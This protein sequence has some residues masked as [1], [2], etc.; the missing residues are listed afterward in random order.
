MTPRP[1]EN[2][3][4]GEPVKEEW[5]LKEQSVAANA[6]SYRNTGKLLQISTYLL[7]IFNIFETAQPQQT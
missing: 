2:I 6:T 4:I 7:N 5:N 1:R 3:H